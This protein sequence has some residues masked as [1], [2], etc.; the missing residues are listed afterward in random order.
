MD[1]LLRDVFDIPE[2]DHT[3]LTA[4]TQDV[5]VD[6]AVRASSI[7]A[8]NSLIENLSFHTAWAAVTGSPPSRWTYTIFNSLLKERK[9]NVD[10][11]IQGSLVECLPLTRVQ[12]PT[13]RKGI[14]DK[15]T[16][17]FLQTHA[18]L[19]ASERDCKRS[20]LE[21]IVWRHCLF[22]RSSELLEAFR[23]KD[24]PLLDAIVKVYVEEAPATLEVFED[25]CSDITDT[26]SAIRG[27]MMDVRNYASR[28]RE[29]I[30]TLNLGV[31]DPVS[32]M[33]VSSAE[34]TSDARNIGWS[35][36]EA[37][38]HGICLNGYL[39]RTDAGGAIFVTSTPSRTTTTTTTSAWSLGDFMDKH[40]HCIR[41]ACMPW[42]IFLSTCPLAIYDRIIVELL[43]NDTAALLKAAE[44][45]ISVA[46]RRS[47]K[48]RL[49]IVPFVISPSSSSSS[50][51]NQVQNA[52]V[53]V[54]LDSSYDAAS[55]A[56]RKNNCLIFPVWNQTNTAPPPD[57]LSTLQADL[58]MRYA[59]APLDPEKPNAVPLHD[60]VLRYV[61]T[62]NLLKPVARHPDDHHKPI[63]GSLVVV[64]NRPNVWS[65]L[66]V[67]VTLDNLD[68]RRWPRVVV[69]C[70]PE[71]ERFVQRSLPPS[72]LPGGVELVTVV[73]ESL[74]YAPPLPGQLPFSIEKYSS[75]LKDAAFWRRLKEVAVGDMAL[76]VQDDGMIVR[77]GIEEDEALMAQD[78]VGA[79]WADAPA[80]AELKRLVP[81]LVGNGGL[82][83][84]RVD[85]C[86]NVTESNTDRMSGGGRLFNFNLQPEPEDVF[87]ARSF[88]AIGRGCP[89]E[90]GERFAME[91]RISSSNDSK[92]FG[93]HKP[94]PYLPKEHLAEFMHQALEE[95]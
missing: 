15:M 81:T 77:P 48:L 6:Q 55:D 3:R 34:D 5:Q 46:T 35:C 11:A 14:V 91:Q 67:L 88:A 24:T 59:R 57:I 66:S 56:L 52:I 63:I 32:E 78:Y 10:D 51:S 21:K 80:N 68:V 2:G 64:D 39:W 86:L 19:R 73:M 44:A 85:A 1:F 23:E 65:M 84:R 50:P 69:F 82:S 94:W 22:P 17:C 30:K 18:R 33:Y 53:C 9:L 79:P 70:A 58:V 12:E 83:L 74:S 26:V 61:H 72:L 92:P 8:H 20:L 27:V 13:S 54:D 95:R 7:L 76:F 40:C 62:R 29:V 45:V 37:L 47:G 16:T 87:F 93:F 41:N 89:T 71:N 38:S 28:T 25:W 31:L 4:L 60:F 43:T 36:I 49:E 90:V 75:L 42:K